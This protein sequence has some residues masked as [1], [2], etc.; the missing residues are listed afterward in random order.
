MHW[1]LMAQ[2]DRGIRALHHSQ[3]LVAEHARL[4]AEVHATLAQ[5]QARRHA[6]AAER[7]RA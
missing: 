4:D 7:R 2:L 5:V 3:E 1:R 6:L